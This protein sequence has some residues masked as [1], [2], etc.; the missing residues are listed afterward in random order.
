MSG[1]HIKYWRQ[2]NRIAGQNIKYILASIFLSAFAHLL[3]YYDVFFS[4]NI[5]VR[6][7]VFAAIVEGGFEWVYDLP[8]FDIVANEKNK[9]AIRI[10]TIAAPAFFYWLLCCTEWFKS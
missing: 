7:V 3:F 8:N 4:Q 10:I 9:K 1:F 2:K 5:L 6:V